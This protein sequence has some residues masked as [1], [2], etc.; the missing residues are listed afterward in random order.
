MNSMTGFGRAEAE[1]DGNRLT[2]EIKSVNHRYLDINLRTPRSLLFLED[3]VRS[4]IKESL[5]RGRV[6]V[7]ISYAR[8]SGAARE[9]KV[10]LDMAKSYADAARQVAEA[11]GA[12]NDLSVSALM[13]MEDVLC[14]EEQQQDGE[15]LKSIMGQAL[16]GAL[17]QLT[18]ARRAEGERIVSDMLERV[19]SIRQT[20][21]KIE[22]L[23]PVAVQQYREK[24]R[25]KLEEFLVDT[26][27]DESRFEAEIL[28]YTDRACINE[29]IVRLS[30]H[31]TQLEQT[32]ADTKAA[33]RN[34]DFLIQELNRELNTIGSKT[35]EVEITRLV[36]SAKSEVEKIREQVQ[37]L[38]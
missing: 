20:V 18:E 19:K 37:N 3:Y 11:T 25:Q 1:Q 13:R 6:D 9:V 15:L 4:V 29:E 28:Y 22:E 8:T 16:L 17:G 31:L 30:S 7:F 26:A 38:E 33:G 10:N 23:E 34:L 12:E 24:L 14:Y 32:L 5:V 35:G 36:V 27:I 21:E 2:I